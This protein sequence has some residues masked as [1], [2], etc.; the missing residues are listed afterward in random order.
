MVA[1]VMVVTIVID[2]CGQGVISQDCLRDV[3]SGN[4]CVVSCPLRSRR[5]GEGIICKESSTGLKNTVLG[6][7][8]D[9]LWSPLLRSLPRFL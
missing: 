7:T 5:D 4:A 3:L 8:G 9:E 1:A 6:Q 2:T